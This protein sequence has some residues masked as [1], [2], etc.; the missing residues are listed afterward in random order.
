MS[1]MGVCLSALYF[2]AVLFAFLNDRRRARLHRAE[3]GDLD[4]DEMSPLEYGVDPVEAGVP[5]DRID[6]VA[7]ARPL[8]RGYDDVT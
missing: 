6:P 4:D 2:A 3:Y 1:A 8:A 7:P 5:V